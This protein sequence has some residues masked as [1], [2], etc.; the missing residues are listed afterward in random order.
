MQCGQ[1]DPKLLVLFFTQKESSEWSVGQ[2][3]QQH[4]GI[5][6]GRSNLFSSQNSHPLV[7]NK[8]T[9][10]MDK[11]FCIALKTELINKAFAT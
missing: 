3:L 2:F 8:W 1:N 5:I 10:H 4:H 9:N 11:L 6:S 7:N